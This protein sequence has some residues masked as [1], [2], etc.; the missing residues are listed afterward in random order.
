MLD[1][2]LS[3][4]N[5]KTSGHTLSN[6]LQQGKNYLQKL[7]NINRRTRIIE[8]LETMT[9]ETSSNSINTEHE[10]NLQ[11]LQQLED[12]FNDQ[13]SRYSVAYREYSTQ[14]RDS[15]GEENT[16]ANDSNVVAINDEL[17]NTANKIY[18]KINEIQ[19]KNVE[20]KQLTER[21][22]EVLGQQLTQYKALYGKINNIA[23]RQGTFNAL[24]NDSQL[25]YK[26]SN[27]QFTIWV[28]VSGL[29]LLIAINHLRK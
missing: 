24:F 7:S 18:E 2:L 19:D 8:G 3:I 21:Q 25:N 12:V 4:F 1:K 5:T 16:T 28:L 29:L 27:V 26:S 17:I 13:L 23:N 20:N 9:T 6:D 11:E 10:K 15:L 14:L 22:E